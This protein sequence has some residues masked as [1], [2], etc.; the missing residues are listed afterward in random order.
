MSISRA[1]V[2]LFL[3]MLTLTA[4]A[5]AS[6]QHGGYCAPVYQRQVYNYPTVVK[7]EVIVEKDVLVATFVPLVVTVPTYSATYV[8]GY[9]QQASY[10]PAQAVGQPVQP[11]PPGQSFDV[12]A[13]AQTLT[14]IN[15]RLT[16]IE[17]SL[18]GGASATGQG[19]D[20]A[21][22]FVAK[23]ASCHDQGVAESKGG[24][25]ALTQGPSLLNLGDKQVAK[26]LV[27]TYSGRMPKGGKL[28]DQEVGLI[29]AW[30]DAMTSGKVVTAAKPQPANP[31][32]QP[33]K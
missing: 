14:R 20:F 9:V 31:E 27:E 30:G 5:P 11:V 16:T 19:N 24:K 22:L 33:V 3:A 29:M 12:S 26:V 15:D 13:L 4:G 6:A 28:T 7:K 18:Q 25:F 23:C 10:T 21:K 8:G 17:T 32:P 2:S 1:S